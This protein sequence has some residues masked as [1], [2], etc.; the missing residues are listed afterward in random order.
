MARVMVK[1]E[2]DGQVLR[3]AK[4]KSMCATSIFGA[5][6]CLVGLE[7]GIGVAKTSLPSDAQMV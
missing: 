5:P 4:S 3:T 2:D 6:M 7:I 1:A